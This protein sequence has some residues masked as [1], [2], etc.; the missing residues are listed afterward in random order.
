M[1]TVIPAIVRRPLA[2]LAV[3]AVVTGITSAAC[4]GG[5]SGTSTYGADNGVGARPPAAILAAARAAVRAAGSV[6]ITGVVARSSRR[7]RLDISV[8]TKHG[9]ARGTIAGNGTTIRFVKAHRL[10][11]V[12]APARFYVALGVPSIAAS[13]A[14]GRW[15]RLP[16]TSPVLADVGRFADPGALLEPVGA[17][18]KGGERLVADTPVVSVTDRLGTVDIRTTGTPYPLRFTGA[19]SSKVTLLFSRFGTKARVAVPRH[20]YPISVLRG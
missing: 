6:H 1:T 4:S 8:D 10:I 19:G 5:S 15:L 11:Y 7:F 16:L 18:R 3:L 13:R 12:R 9:T 14:S 2:A 20:S 17:L